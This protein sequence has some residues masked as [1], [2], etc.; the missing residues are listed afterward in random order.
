M[1]QP[2][3]ESVA[4]AALARVGFLLGRAVYGNP[5]RWVLGLAVA[6]A[7]VAYIGLRL[8]IV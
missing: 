6:G 1:P 2:G 7:L 8:R 5:A 4:V 3:W